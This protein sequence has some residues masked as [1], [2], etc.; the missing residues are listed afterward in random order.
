MSRSLEAE[1]HLIACALVDD[2]KT[3]ALMEIPEDWF[4]LNSSKL[5][6]RTIRDL[7]SQNLSADIFAIADELERNR[8]LDMAGG[9]SYLTEMAESLPNLGFWTSYKNSLFESYKH[10]MIEQLMQTTSM[11]VG[12]GA[13]AGE[14]IETL[15]AGLVDLLTDHHQ[16]GLEKISKHLDSALEYIQWKQDNEG[17]VRGTETG[18]NQLDYALDGFQDGLMYAICG[19]PAMG[20]TMVALNIANRLAKKGPVCYFSLEMTGGMLSQRLISAEAKVSSHH[21]KRGDM[22]NDQN[23]DVAMAVTRLHELSSLYIDESAGLTVSAVRSRLKAF[24]VKHGN[25]G[26]VFIDHIGLLKKRQGSSP[27]E[28]LTEIVHELQVMAK[29]FNCPLIIVS[30]LNRNCETRSDPRP[31]MSDIRE[32]GAIEEDCRGV[33]FVYRDEYY[34]KEQSQQKNITELILAKNNLGETGTFYFHHDLSVGQYEEISDYQ[35][36][37]PEPK[38]GKVYGK[39]KL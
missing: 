4:S 14:I 23:N 6:I 15:Q 25:V 7:V 11:L 31:M 13:K 26:A 10:R 32:T 36:P 37:E 16:G 21:F 17:A 27:Y 12:T 8:K 19:R 18:F 24:Q 28:G 29:E 20:K 33:L 1:Q 3:A 34:T 5:I 22:N 9:M 2:A 38:M 30:Q 35:K 39:G